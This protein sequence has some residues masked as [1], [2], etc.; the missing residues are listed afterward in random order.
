MRTYMH[1]YTHTYML[2]ETKRKDAQKLT[3]AR[4]N[5]ST[6]CVHND[7]KKVQQN[8]KNATIPRIAHYTKKKN[9]EWNLSVAA[10]HLDWRKAATSKHEIGHFETHIE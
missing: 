8:L 9:W 4:R 3:N 10:C 5:H 6:A 7:L 1:A 2:K